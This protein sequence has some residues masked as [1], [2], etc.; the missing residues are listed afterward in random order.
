M[1]RVVN[2]RK[3]DEEAAREKLDKELDRELEAS[4]PAS[5]APKITRTNSLTRFSRQRPQNVNT[6]TNRF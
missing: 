5:D 3:T 6:S 2:H 1:Q 4:F